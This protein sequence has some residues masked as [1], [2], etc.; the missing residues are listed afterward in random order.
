MVAVAVRVVAE[1]GEHAGAQHDAESRLAEVDL[2]VR[3]RPKPCVT[4]SSNAGIWAFSP[5]I[6]RIWETA[7]VA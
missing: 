5:T 1:L 7:M 3:C 4:T 2:N 6:S